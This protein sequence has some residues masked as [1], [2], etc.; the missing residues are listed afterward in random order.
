[1]SLISSAAHTNFN[2]AGAEHSDFALEL[3]ACAPPHQLR[4]HMCAPLFNC[5]QGGNFG[6][7]DL[8]EHGECLQLCAARA[9]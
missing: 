3:W 1:Q 4:R 5:E 6:A 7:S 9:L 8:L 2:I